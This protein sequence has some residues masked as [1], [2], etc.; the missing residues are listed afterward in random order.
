MID[1]A[2]GKVSD[3]NAGEKSRMADRDGHGAVDS[4]LDRASGSA[5][6]PRPEDEHGYSYRVVTVGEAVERAVSGEW[7]VPEFQRQF[8][9][10][11]PQVCGLADSLWRNYPIGALLL[12]R[13][14]N[15]GDDAS[16]SGW[17]IA[18]G[19][20]RLT[21][22]CILC[23]RE[24]V[25]LKRKPA[26]F[27]TRL[28][29]RFDL[30]FDVGGDGPP[31]F[32]AAR[33]TASAYDPHLVSVRSL[34][35]IDPC[36]ERGRSE[37]ERLARE[38]KALECYRELDTSEIYRRL[39][40]VSIIRQRE[41]VATLVQY[42]REDVLEIFERLNSRGMRFRRLLLKLAMEEIPAAIRGVHR[43]LGR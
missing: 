3:A 30:S 16:L 27:R 15:G 29:K 9:W 34:M 36:D 20:Q 18:D 7:D 39:R 40:Q 21:S 6:A 23:G 11:P 2:S 13:S 35:A 19:Q 14:A 33:A 8:V 5:Q 25:W 43:Q 41:L 26:A 4:S 1:D 42:E 12:W 28:L 22:L 32:L 24:P 38:L 37:L 17:W 31:G 10:Q